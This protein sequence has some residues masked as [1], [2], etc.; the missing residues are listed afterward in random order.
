MK[1]L[2]FTFALLL[3]G[4]ATAQTTPPAEPAM[5]APAPTG[6]APMPPTT[7]EAAQPPMQTPMETMPAPAAPTMAPM[8]AS[9]APA[10]QAE[11]PRCSKSVTD[12]CVQSSAREADVK[13]GAPAHRKRRTR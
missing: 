10:A 8:T 9:P 5:P 11:Y 2:A 7:P 12:Q 1:T 13:G 6:D 4:A 3:S